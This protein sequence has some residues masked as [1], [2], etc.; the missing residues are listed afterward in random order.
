MT[1][2][3]MQDRISH[4]IIRTGLT[5]SALLTGSL[6][7]GSL[8][9]TLVAPVSTL[10]AQ[11]STT[12]T[13][14]TFI[15]LGDAARLAARNSASA[16][17]ARARVGEAQARVTQRRADL[18]PNLSAAGSQVRR[19]LNTASFGIS[20]PTAPGEPPLFDPNG[21]VI[22]PFTTID[23]RGRLVQPVLDFGAIARLRGARAAVT[24]SSAEAT[25][26]SEQAGTQAAVA[27][28]RAIRSADDFRA[29][30]EDSVL[31]ADLV[32]VAQAQ[33]QA[34]TGIALDVTRARSQLAATRAQ[35]IASRAARDRTMIDLVR[36]LNLPVG[37]RL[38]LADSLGALDSTGVSTDE[39][40]ATRRAL[41]SRPDLIAAQARVAAARQSVSSVRAERLPTLSLVGDDGFNGLSYSHL[42]NTYEYGFQLSVPILDGFRRE[43]RVQEQEGV[44]REAE[45]QQHDIEQQAAADVRGALIDLHSASEQVGATRERLGLAEQEVAQARERFR[46]GVAGNAD[47]IT[48]LLSLTT[49][50]TAVIDAQTS[51]QTARVALARA[52]GTVTTLP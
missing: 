11:D 21:Q 45:I 22:P 5:R 17:G 4:H 28:V 43:G 6:L 40:Q 41:Q 24:A 37:S 42:L 7:A 14:P 33:L 39:Q 18:L 30:S 16:L 50:H 13:G 19:T 8:V 32:T 47:V 12:A 49:A 26:T 23:Y 1:H 10:A 29:R 35:L 27:Y 36:A 3:S 51:Y 20:F 31:A 52:Q 15:S 38:A 34:G 2:T 25:A 48:A 9:A 44:V 46:A